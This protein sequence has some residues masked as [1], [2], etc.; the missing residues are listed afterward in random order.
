MTVSYPVTFHQDFT[1]FECS[2]F[3][4]SQTE[5]CRIAVLIAA[6]NILELHIYSS[7]NIIIFS[8]DMVSIICYFVGR[9]P[10]S[11]GRVLFSVHA[12]VVGAGNFSWWQLVWSAWQWF[13]GTEDT[14]KWWVQFAHN[15]EFEYFALRVLTNHICR[16]LGLYFQLC[17]VNTWQ[18]WLPASIMACIHA[19]M[20]Y[21]NFSMYTAGN[22]HIFMLAFFLP[23]NSVQ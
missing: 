22:R 14:A 7:A 19:S 10:I 5:R 9:H 20:L 18:D 16:S 11:M 23:F 12:P 2:Y 1:I 15:K 6:S 17:S 3:F 8:I 13:V 21:T 4:L